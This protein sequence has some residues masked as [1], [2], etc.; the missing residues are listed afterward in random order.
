[1]TSEPS[2]RHRTGT[3]ITAR[4]IAFQFAP[5]LLA[6]TAGY[7]LAHYAGLLVSLSPALMMALT[8]PLSPPAN[9]LVLSVPSWFEGLGIAFVLIGHLLAIWAAHAVVYDLFSNRLVAIQSQYP[10]VAV[11][12]GYTVISLWIISLPGAIPLYLS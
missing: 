1:M 12:I 11:M 5:P 8:S 2:S 9:L 7:H 10:F 4:T 3:Y 6:I